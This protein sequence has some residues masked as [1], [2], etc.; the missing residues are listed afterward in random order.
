MVFNLALRSR[1]VYLHAEQ[2]NEGV[3]SCFIPTSEL[4]TQSLFNNFNAIPKYKV[5]INSVLLHSFVKRNGLLACIESIYPNSN[6]RLFISL[7]Y[8]RYSGTREVCKST[9]YCWFFDFSFLD[10]LRIFDDFTP[11]IFVQKYYKK[12]H[13]ELKNILKPISNTFLF[14]VF[15][16]VSIFKVIISCADGLLHFVNHLSF[17]SLAVFRND[18]FVA[19]NF[20]CV[21][22]KILKLIFLS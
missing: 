10:N 22:L 18:N 14:Y 8:L 2:G 15:Q 7:L 3:E 6:R 19:F 4:W 9:G 1:T 11:T 20:Q 12:I 16:I 21:F 17:F 13:R 5:L